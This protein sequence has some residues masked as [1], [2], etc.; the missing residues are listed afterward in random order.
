MEPEISFW[1]ANVLTMD[2]LSKVKEFSI[3]PS[4]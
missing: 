1:Y 3:K 2:E 4:K